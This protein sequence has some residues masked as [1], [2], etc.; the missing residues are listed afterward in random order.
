MEVYETNDDENGPKAR[1]RRGMNKKET[2]ERSP[3]SIFT[4][5]SDRHPV[6]KLNSWLLRYFVVKSKSGS[7]S[8]QVVDFPPSECDLKT[9]STL[10]ADEIPQFR[11]PRATIFRNS[12]AY[13]SRKIMIF[14]RLRKNPAIFVQFRMRSA[15]CGIRRTEIGNRRLE[16][17]NCV[18]SVADCG[19]SWRIV[20]GK[21]FLT[22]C[23]PACRD[24]ASERRRVSICGENSYA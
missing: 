9:H 1:E 15:E 12:T 16:I 24:A 23:E 14:R 11:T 22:L 21:I 7:E 19:R 10:Q 5:S 20:A 6:K 8:A 13:S 18:R 3:E 4:A 17:G 2:K